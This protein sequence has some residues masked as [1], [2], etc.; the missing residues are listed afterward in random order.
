MVIIPKEKPVIEN[1]NSYYVDIQKLLEHY[2]GELES[3]GIY[4]RSPAVEGII[5]F[6]KDAL[7]SGVYKDREKEV[8]GKEAID[9]I[10]KAVENQNFKIDVISISPDK[11][12]FWANLSNSKSIYQGLSTEFTDL[13]GLIKKM[14]AEGL[15]GYIDVSIG[16]GE[17]GG[18]IFL[19]NGQVIDDSYCRGKEPISGAEKTQEYLIRRTKESGG[20]FNVFKI[21]PRKE[22]E[23]PPVS[24]VEEVVEPVKE[25]VD[26]ISILEELMQS[27]E[28]M[29][30]RE[31]IKTEFNIA[32]RKILVDRADEYPF[33][34]PF[35]GEFEY[36]G[37]RIE[38][39][40]SA[41]M[42]EMAT[43]LIDI[44]N[45]LAEDIGLRDQWEDQYRRW[46][47]KH[48]NELDASGIRH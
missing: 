20:V 18:V 31:K 3:G 25:G 44:L 2:Q 8:D 10:I 34:D 37:G 40:G 48:S 33:L 13:D 47:E 1:L 19:A 21:I 14:Q 43:A 15:T 46:S 23:E 12:Y 5:F 41:G 36:S 42:E 16:N 39:S 22:V 45:L 38:Y 35:A 26:F 24:T 7:L 30:Q 11:V 28:E 27:F 29:M 17:D 4:F 32:L 6:D 9:L